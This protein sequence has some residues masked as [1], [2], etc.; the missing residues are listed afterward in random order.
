MKESPKLL[1]VQARLTSILVESYRVSILI[2]TATSTKISFPDNI[3]LRDLNEDISISNQDITIDKDGLYAIGFTV[4][5]ESNSTGRRRAWM[6][7]NDVTNTRYGDIQVNSVS[8]GTT[9]LSG[10]AIANLSATDTVQV[11][12]VQYSGGN[13]NVGGSGASRCKRFAYRLGH[14]V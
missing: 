14:N 1:L 7:V 8:S 2:A 6:T 10:F 12:A 3:D 9:S 4:T 11:Y 5:F 13:L